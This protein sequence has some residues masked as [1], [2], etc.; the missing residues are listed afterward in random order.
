[1]NVVFHGATIVLN[2]RSE[3]LFFQFAVY[4]NGLGPSFGLGFVPSVDPEGGDGVMIPVLL[5]LYGDLL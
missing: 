1:M 4:V 5:E 3:L 2:W